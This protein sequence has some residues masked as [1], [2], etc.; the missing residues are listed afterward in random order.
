MISKE[1]FSKTPL[2]DEED[3]LSCKI[4]ADVEAVDSLTVFPPEYFVSYPF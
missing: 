3:D 4:E 1:R 2:R